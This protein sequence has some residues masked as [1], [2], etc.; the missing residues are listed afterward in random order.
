MINE[1]MNSVADRGDLLQAPFP[2]FGG[3]SKIADLVWSRFGDVRSYVE[4]FAGS[5]AVLLKR[6]QPFDGPETVNDLDGMIS[7][8]WRAIRSDP[9]TVVKYADWPAFENDLHAR[10]IWLVERKE[11][12]QAKLEGDPNYFDPKIAGWWVWGI[13]CWI[14]SGW[15]SGDGGW[16]IVTD[17]N[18]LRQLIYLAGK[19]QGVQ[20][21]RVHLGDE[22]R[23]VQRRRVQLGNE[24]R[25]VQRKIDLYDWFYKLF[26][27]LQRVRVCCGDWTRICGG[28]DGDSVGHMVKRVPCG[29]FL[30]PPY[31][32]LAL[33]DPKCYRVD[34]FQ[35]AHNVREWAIRYGDDPRFRI[36]LCGYDGE[37]EMP[38][39]WECVSWK[40]NGGMANQSSNRQGRINAHRERVWFSPHCLRSSMKQKTLF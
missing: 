19:G 1:L 37:H 20:R 34:D 17:D 18:G 13:A 6:P 28:K 30:D 5:L 12:L 36:A 21:R 4:P 8:F 22:G 39:S 7:N 9:D 2:Y 14:G 11:S 25:G 3:K 35:V 26:D 15:C 29:V 31:S 10:H 38:E 33:R 24:G 27:R 32:D 23:G 40:A 16:K